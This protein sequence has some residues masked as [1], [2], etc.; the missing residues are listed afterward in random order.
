MKV[1]ALALLLQLLFVFPFLRLRKHLA[2]RVEKT[3]RR[4]KN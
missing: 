4:S 1:K 3:S 2:G